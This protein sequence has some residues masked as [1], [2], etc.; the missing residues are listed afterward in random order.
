M[1][2]TRS[3]T[4]EDDIQEV[5]GISEDL[6]QQEKEDRMRREDNGEKEMEVHT[7]E[8]EIQQTAVNDGQIKEKDDIQEENGISEDL[9]QQEKEDYM[10]REDNGDQEMEVHKAETEIQQTTVNDGQIKEKEGA[11]LSETE[12]GRNKEL[13]QQRFAVWGGQQK[14][15]LYFSKMDAESMAA[16]KRSKMRG[17]QT[18]KGPGMQGDNESGPQTSKHVD[19]E[20]REGFRRTIL[21]AIL[22]Q[23]RVGHY[24]RE[25]GERA[26]G[27]SDQETGQSEDDKR[28]EEDQAGKIRTESGHDM[29]VTNDGGESGDSQD[30]TKRGQRD[31]TAGEEADDEERMEEKEKE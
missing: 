18:N 1:E 27:V 19:I 28:G 6:C 16:N 24:P 25:C 13:P 9:C 5:N 26:A 23:K 22:Q 15:V 8:T 7:T 10:R 3:C 30:I 4:R 11:T 20:Q 12:V 21:H 2:E 14:T 31:E 29:D 17:G